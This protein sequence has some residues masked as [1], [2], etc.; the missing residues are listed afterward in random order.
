MNDLLEMLNPMVA[1]IANEFART[2]RTHGAGAED[3]RQ[4][5]YLWVAENEYKAAAW[6]DPELTP[7]ADGVRL[8]ARALR[9]RCKGYGV[10]VKA[11]ALG[12]EVSDLHWYTK[13]EVRALLPLMFNESAWHEPPR[14]EGRTAKS[15][16]EG[17]NWIATL[18][19]VAQAFKRLDSE[20]QHILRRFHED[21]WT[22]RLTAEAEGVSEASMSRRHDRAVSRLVG[23]LGG[24]RPEGLAA[25]D[26]WKGRRAVTNSAARAYQ[27]AVYE[28]DR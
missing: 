25:R 21:G 5:M 6:L 1:Q 19:D 18:A 16:A 24:E 13:G 20:D 28:E 11:Q 23:L 15:P 9:N 7:E 12:Y 2:Y 10:N 27:S 4:E 22:N 17:G 14:S 26:P 3:F 8:L